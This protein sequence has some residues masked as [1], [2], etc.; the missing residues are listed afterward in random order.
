MDEHSYLL[1]LSRYVHLNPV[2]IKAKAQRPESERIREI[3]RYRWS[4]LHGYLEGKRKASWVTYEVVLG[5][6][7]ESG[8]NTR[9]SFKMVLNQFDFDR[10]RGYP[11]LPTLAALLQQFQCMP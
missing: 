7:G 2:R 6:V 10:H 5:Y 8:I 1:E 11:A 3:S 9:N 4:S